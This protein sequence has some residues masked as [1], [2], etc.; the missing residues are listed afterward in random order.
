MAAI[1]RMKEIKQAYI[2][3]EKKFI[4]LLCNIYLTFFL[5]QFKIIHI[6]YE[7]IKIFVN[8]TFAHQNFR[9]QFP[10]SIELWIEL[11]ADAR[12]IPEKDLLKKRFL[13]LLKGM[14]YMVA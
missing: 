10:D 12:S 14:L 13:I 4:N 11:P 8:F 2:Y 5:S 7:E 6:T 3:A 9:T 1:I